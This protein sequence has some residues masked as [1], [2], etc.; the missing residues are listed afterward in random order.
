MIDR[1]TE[2]DKMAIAIRQILETVNVYKIDNYEQA[3]D[4]SSKLISLEHA[5][6][7]ERLRLNSVRTNNVLVEFLV[8]NA[9]VVDPGSIDEYEEP[10]S[11][12]YLD[13]EI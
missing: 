4:I 11:S 3:V 7:Q 2:V 12:S 5:I 6:H 1:R 8:E 13:D 9:A 10:S